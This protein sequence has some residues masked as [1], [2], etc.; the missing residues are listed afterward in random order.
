MHFFGLWLVLEHFDQFVAIHHLAGRD[1]EV[2]SNPEGSAV[3]LARPTLVLDHIVEEV[4]GAAEQAATG[5]LEG[6]HQCRRVRGEEVGGRHRVGQE[7]RGERG[8]RCRGT[9]EVGGVHELAQQALGEQV[10]LEERVEEEI[11]VPCARAEARVL[12]I[13]VS[14]VGEP[15][16]DETTTEPGTH[17]PQPGSI[18]HARRY[19]RPRATGRAPHRARERAAQR[20]RIGLVERALDDSQ[21][22]AD[23]AGEWFLVVC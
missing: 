6:A 13:G 12:R 21:R 7:L 11:V 17:E 20:D 16:T 9:L 22:V 8:L 18:A 19:R 23:R 4:A 1:R 3:D 5:G 14:E 10:R 2:L 15:D